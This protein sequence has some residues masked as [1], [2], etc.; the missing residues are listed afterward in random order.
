MTQERALSILKT[1]ANVFLT[2][3]PGAG[4]TYTIN[5]YIQYL[6]AH[7]IEPAITA[8]TG[9]AATH[10]HGQTIHSWAGIGILRELSPYDLEKIASVEY[11]NKRIRKT[12]VLI[13]DEVSML[14]AKTLDAVDAVCREIRQREEPF[15]GMQI[16]FVGD[17][18]QLPPIAKGMQAQFAFESSAWIKASPLICY[19]SEQHRQTDDATYLELLTAIRKG[20]YTEAH[21]SLIAARQQQEIVID[22]DSEYCTQLY[23]HNVDVDTLNE[24]ELEKLG[25]L[26]TIFRMSTKGKQSLV[27]ALKRG[28]LSPEVLALKKD[29]LIICTKNNKDKGYVNGTT[30]VVVDFERGTRYPIIETKQGNRIVVEPVSWEIEEDGKI[31]ASITQIPLRLAWAITIHKSQGLSLDRAVMDLSEV[32]EYGQG[33]VALSR[34]KSLKG[35]QILGWNT[36]AF[37]VH[38]YI[39][40]RDQDFLQASRLADAH[41]GDIP[42]ADLRSLQQNFLRAHGG[43]VVAGSIQSTPTKRGDTLTETKV[44]VLKELSLKKI[45]TTRKL[46]VAT[47]LTHIEKLVS[48]KNL[49]KEDIRY[50]LSDQV[51]GALHTIERTFQ[52]YDTTKL[53]PVHQHF[54]ERFTYEDLHLA[55]TYLFG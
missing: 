22:R 42:E 28:C 4:K 14:D 19:L 53:T 34:V 48:S 21:E 7:G 38:P 47:I 31:K 30:G 12:Q 10:L 20:V 55:R 3:E 40:E 36:R 26:P 6:R 18:F 45:A 2:G 25:G 1:G 11:L 50:L 24:R 51:V 37:Q 29:A 23:A 46:T 32:F 17:F 44:L 52:S 39:R 5:T 15:G 16:I 49:E 33:Y 27:D 43:I 54:K 8:S 9:I 13:I 35:L 41:F